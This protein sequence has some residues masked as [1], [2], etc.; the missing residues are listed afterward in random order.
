MSHE[1]H[2]TWLSPHN[3]GSFVMDCVEPLLHEDE[4]KPSSSSN[5]KDLP[6][7]SLTLYDVKLQICPCFAV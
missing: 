4:A 3:I 7:P 2:P 5:S 1:D 6:I